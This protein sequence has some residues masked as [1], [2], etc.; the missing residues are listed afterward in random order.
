MYRKKMCERRIE[1]KVEGNNYY[2]GNGFLTAV[3][4]VSNKV[5]VYFVGKGY[6]WFSRELVKPFNWL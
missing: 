4:R 2:S 5:C 3:D 6:I 1:V